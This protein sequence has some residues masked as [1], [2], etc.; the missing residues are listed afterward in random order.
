MTV[1]P[2]NLSPQPQ[3]QP[4]PD[5]QEGDPDSGIPDPDVS[6]PNLQVL[7]PLPHDKNPEDL[8]L[9]SLHLLIIS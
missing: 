5:S 9:D 1:N 7:V 6:D 3:P 8:P 4:Q 2:H